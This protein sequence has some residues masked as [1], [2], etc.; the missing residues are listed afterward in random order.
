MAPDT[1]ALPPLS[2]TPRLAPPWN[3]E[4][5]SG[6]SISASALS[7]RDAFH[8]SGQCWPR[9]SS[10]VTRRSAGAPGWIPAASWPA[11]ATRAICGLVDA[12]QGPSPSPPPREA[13]IRSAGRHGRSR[14]AEGDASQNTPA[15]PPFC[16]K[17]EDSSLSTSRRR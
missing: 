14:I 17:A 15:A 7:G 10:R 13:P 2:D 9:A 8:R 12:K 6:E 11:A 4:R 5:P 16:P 1:R 3:L